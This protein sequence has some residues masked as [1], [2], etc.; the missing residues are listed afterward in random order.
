MVKFFHMETCVFTAA[1]RERQR[2]TE[3]ATDRQTDRDT[4]LCDTRNRTDMVRL[5]AK[6]LMTA[7]PSRLPRCPCHDQEIIHTV[8]VPHVP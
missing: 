5:P 4:D 2:Q 7:Q 1:E 8:Y 3:R 6:R